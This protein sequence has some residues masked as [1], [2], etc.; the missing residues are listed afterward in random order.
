[1]PRQGL[2]DEGRSRYK[3]MLHCIMIITS[4]VPPELPMELS[5]AVNTSLLAL[6]KI[7]V[8]CTEPFRIPSAGKVQVCCFDKTGTLTS[9]NFH[10]VGVAEAAEAPAVTLPEAIGEWAACVLGAC[11]SLV[12]VEGKLSGDPMERAALGALRRRVVRRIVASSHRCNC[13]PRRSIAC[14]IV[15]LRWVRC[16]VA[17]AIGWSFSKADV[18]TSRRGTRKV[19]LLAPAPSPRAGRHISAR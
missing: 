6:M 5:L 14:C 8:F 9:D 12:H 17:D 1:M 15:A 4:V 18:A 16:T 10:A 7:G 19:P 11:H 2:L 3:L 13:T